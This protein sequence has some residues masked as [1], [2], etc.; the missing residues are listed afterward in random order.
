MTKSL[1]PPKQIFNKREYFLHSEGWDPNKISADLDAVILGMHA[2]RIIPELARAKEL[3]VKIYSFLN[4][5]TRK[6]FRNNGLPLVEVMVKR[7][8]LQ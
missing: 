3:G 4:I 1:N 7:P 6:V 8:L 5:S 2:K